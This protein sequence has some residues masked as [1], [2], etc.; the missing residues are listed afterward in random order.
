MS[1]KF[2]LY[3]ACQRWFAKWYSHFGMLIDGL[4][5]VDRWSLII[6]DSWFAFLNSGN[7]TKR[8]KK[9]SKEEPRSI[10]YC[11]NFEWY[12][13]MSTSDWTDFIENCCQYLE[14]RLFFFVRFFFICKFIGGGGQKKQTHMTNWRQCFYWHR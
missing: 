13:V 14:I 6:V 4:P 3:F 11:R 2:F 5:I 8:L 10:L 12:Y 7:S 1:D 9:K